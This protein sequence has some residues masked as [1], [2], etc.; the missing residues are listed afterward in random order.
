MRVLAA[1][2]P[3]AKTRIGETEDTVTIVVEGPTVTAD[4]LL[5]LAANAGV[6]V[7]NTSHSHADGA[8][9]RD[10]GPLPTARNA[11]E[12]AALRSFRRRT[13]A[14]RVSTTRSAPADETSDD[15]AN[16]SELSNNMTDEITELTELRDSIDAELAELG[17]EISGIQDQLDAI[18]AEIESTVAERDTAVEAFLPDEEV[19][20]TVTTETRGTIAS[21]LD[22]L[23]EKRDV[24]SE[25]V[26]LK[27]DRL[28]A[29]VKRASDVRDSI[30]ETESA[31]ERIA[32]RTD[33]A[34]ARLADAR[35]ELD[36]AQSRLDD[37]LAVL[38]QRLDPFDIDLTLETLGT[39]IEE[40]IPEQRSQMRA[41]L[42]GL[43]ERV[44]ELSAREAKL[45]KDRDKLQ[46]VDGGG[47]CPTCNQNVGSD[48]S[49]SELDAVEEELH[50]VKRR[51][52]AAE[53]DRDEKI[54][55]LEE[56]DDLRDR[57][58]RLR[59]FR[60]ETMAVAAG[61]VE[62]RQAN[63]ADLQADLEEE[64][65]ELA[66]MKAERDEA[67]EAIATL[68][69]DIDSLVAEIDSLQE[70]ASE[71]EASLAA[72]DVVDDL[73]V[74]LTERVEQLWECQAAFEEKEAE[75]AAL[76]AEIEAL[77]DE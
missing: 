52:G 7:V 37:D 28:K 46:S 73:Q 75:R 1:R 24:R 2:C 51:L 26:A 49:A 63:L 55:G 69:S 6:A 32:E 8:A 71:G 27:H 34:A 13:G 42:D 74:Q 77:T 45:T 44:T 17:V 59:L 30:A 62:D 64:R 48:R 61:R 66:E 15:P 21:H 65:E 33:E 14:D 58:I 57:A 11:I 12:T 67:D 25:T 18:E 38:A 40:Q 23:G 9:T 16:G 31:I 53:R 22:R 39:V 60:S 5:Q 36:A 35:D 56:L 70:Q 20:E 19:P 47:T 50:H 68:E 10:C 72:F 76:D 43:R 54:A 3:V 29:E 4:R 41:A